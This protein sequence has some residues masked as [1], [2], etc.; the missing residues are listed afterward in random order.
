MVLVV[1]TQPSLLVT[2]SEVKTALGESSTDRDAMITTALRAAQAELDGPSGRVGMVVASTTVEQRSPGFDDPI[3]L[4]AVPVTSV[5]TIKYLDTAGVEQTLSAGSYTVLSDGRIELNPG[6]SWPG[7]YADE[8]AVRIRFVAGMAA[9]DIRI[10]LMKAA[11][12]M[13]VKM[14]IDMADPAVYQNTIRNLL[15]PLRAWL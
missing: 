4:S 5:T 13:H 9:G 3:V 14:T 6:Y 15:V 2:L 8:E 12:I 1:I 7:L 10:D 11:I